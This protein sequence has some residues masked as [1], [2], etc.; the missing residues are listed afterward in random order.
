ME[1]DILRL[2]LFFAGLALIAGIYLADRYK[3]AKYREDA[4]SPSQDDAVSERPMRTAVRR[5]PL[6]K[7]QEPDEEV[8]DPQFLQQEEP[9]MPETVEPEPQEP[10]PGAAETTGPVLEGPDLEVLETVTANTEDSPQEPVDMQVA[11]WDLE[12][13]GELI[14]EERSKKREPRREGEQF[15]F[16]FLNTDA[17][18]KEK[19][20]KEKPPLPTKLIQLN[21]VPRQGQ[22]LGQEILYA[23]SETRLQFGDLNIYHFPDEEAPAG[24]PLFSMANLVEPGSFNPEQM[25]DFSTPGLV[26]FAM[27]PGSK[28]GLTV[29]SE[30]L[31]T[32]EQ[33]ATLLDGELKDD[34]HSDLSK[35]TIEHMR[36]E[37]QEFH[38]KLQLA[39][40]AR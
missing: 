14:Q 19:V 36:E 21:L 1:A 24:E 10:E 7:P 5:E 13:L 11:D 40:S 25:D 26:L 12:Q 23:V 6:W 4:T 31:H 9:E 15:S 32:A 20:E 33:L 30:M 37:I 3:R 2:I 35:Q 18:E 38:R 22:F 28:D 34:S 39:K 27:L 29:F 17:P 16:S 8:N